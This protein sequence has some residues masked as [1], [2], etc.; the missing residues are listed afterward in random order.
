VE[1]LGRKGEQ[2]RV[3]YLTILPI[4]LFLRSFFALSVA[5]G[6][7]RVWFFDQASEYGCLAQ[8]LLSGHGYASPFG[9]STGP[10]AFLAPGYPLLVAAAFRLFGAYTLHAA[11]ALI[12][13]QALFGVLIV[14]TV[15]L[16]AKRLIDRTA[17]NLAGALCA[18]S[19]PAICL[20]ILFWETSLS[21]LLLT[22][23]I[24]LALRCVE[25]PGSWL[26][27]GFGAYCA[28]AMFVNPSLLLTFAAI[29]IWMIW[30]TGIS[31][32]KGPALALLTW[33]MIFSIWPIRNAYRLHAFVP[34]RTNLGYELW[35]GN[36]PGSD[37]VFTAS[38]HLNKNNE[39]YARYAELGE[40][41]YMH[42]KS[43]L[44]FAAIK[45]D[46]PRFVRLSLERFRKFW[47]N[48]VD[49]K[50]SSLLSMNIAFTS[51]MSAAGLGLLFWRRNQVAFLLAIPFV[52]LPA[53][54]YVTHADFRFR[55]LLDP[56]AIL[57]TAYVFKELSSRVQSHLR[58]KARSSVV[59]TQHPVQT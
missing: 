4:A 54:Y 33:C 13:L 28:L 47:I 51:L 49:S 8:S 1:P 6:H 12:G 45:A 44:A 56:L 18:I 48:G 9:G 46:K 29:F 16:L 11:A 40:V 17:A 15:M 14:L 43:E 41:A 39:E 52:A 35:Q 53:P 19:P 26:W 59:A 31:R 50:S 57:M 34:L 5:K 7:P 55:L 20:P 2:R 58:T 3:H 22:G 23:I 36:R 24:L 32:L 42:E 37:G 21:M 25:R 38:L 30:Q 27:I 10:S